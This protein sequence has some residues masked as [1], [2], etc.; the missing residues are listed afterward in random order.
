MQEI[1]AGAVHAVRKLALEKEPRNFYEVLSANY[2]LLGKN[3][4]C[5]S[6]EANR[7][8]RTRTCGSA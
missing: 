4:I 5:A 3:C 1:T 6:F 8:T 2:I 7:N